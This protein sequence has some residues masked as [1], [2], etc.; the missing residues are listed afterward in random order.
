[1]TVRD[2]ASAQRGG[3]GQ[4]QQK[5]GKTDMQGMV[6]GL[7]KGDACGLQG[8]MDSSGRQAL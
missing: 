8:N 2:T 5:S 7:M 3:E 6:K 4:G 1:M